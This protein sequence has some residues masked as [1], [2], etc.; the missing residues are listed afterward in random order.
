MPIT[1][2]HERAGPKTLRDGPTLDSPSAACV[3]VWACVDGLIILACACAF[4]GFQLKFLLESSCSQPRI[5]V[6]LH[7][8]EGSPSLQNE[9]LT[10]NRPIHMPHGTPL[11]QTTQ[12]YNGQRCLTNEQ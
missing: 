6:T 5:F 10:Q 12:Q 3:V 8:R 7:E 2:P 1:G 11:L 4:D 9:L